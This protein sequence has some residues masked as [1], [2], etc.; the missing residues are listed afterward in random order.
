MKRSALVRRTPLRLKSKKRQQQDVLRRKLVAH[1]LE[2]YP[3]CVR[4]F[5]ERAVDCHELKRRS[6]GG[7]PLDPT[8][9]ATLCRTCHTW[10][11][12]HPLSA[13]EEGWHRWSYEDVNP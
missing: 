2:T 7:D 3:W 1:L 9:I 8:G 12:E 4:C 13:H 6:Q 11:T 10:V 5:V